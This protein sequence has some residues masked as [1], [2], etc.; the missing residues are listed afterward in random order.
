[1]DLSMHSQSGVQRRAPMHGMK[2]A[3]TT[4]TFPALSGWLAGWLLHVR[5]NTNPESY[6]ATCNGLK[7]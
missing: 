7:C 1:M 6:S 3:H 2:L 5:P 4:T